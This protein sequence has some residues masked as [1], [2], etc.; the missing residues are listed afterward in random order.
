[1]VPTSTITAVL[2]S[3]G[4]C[5]HGDARDDGAGGGGDSAD[6]DNIT[7]TNTHDHDHPVCPG[8]GERPGSEYVT[9]N[10]VCGLVVEFVVLVL[11]CAGFCAGD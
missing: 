3:T 11:V 4:L 5:E 9:K 8:S 7:S 1:M 6:E 10:I 2:W